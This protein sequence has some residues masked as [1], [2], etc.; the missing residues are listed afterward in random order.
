[1]KAELLAAVKVQLCSQQIGGQMKP[2]RLNGNEHCL[3]LWILNV[4]LLQRHSSSHLRTAAEVQFGSLLYV[5]DAVLAG[6]GQRKT[7]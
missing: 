3:R 5:E 7:L 4:R 1:M 6:K 2:I